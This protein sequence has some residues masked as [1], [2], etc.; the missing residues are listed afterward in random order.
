[1]APKVAKKTKKSKAE[2]EAEKLAREEEERK[3]RILEE[4]RQLEEN[5]RLRIEAIRKQA[6]RDEFRTQELARLNAEYEELLDDLHYRQKLMMNEETIEVS[7]MMRFSWNMKKCWKLQHA[8]DIFNI[9][10]MELEKV[11][12]F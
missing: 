10:F 2:V 4:K 5:E 11:L 3:A 6:E 12:V 8:Y 7:E 9:L 1:M